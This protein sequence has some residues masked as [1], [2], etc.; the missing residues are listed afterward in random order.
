MLGTVLPR[1]RVSVSVVAEVVVDRP[2]GLSAHVGRDVGAIGT[3]IAVY[4]F[5]GGAV[6]G[7]RSCAGGGI[8][9]K[10]VEDVEGTVYDWRR[11]RGPNWRWLGEKCANDHH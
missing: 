11:H 5:H 9:R 1:I 7:S 10:F 3:V 4:P 8:A 6:Y 2:V